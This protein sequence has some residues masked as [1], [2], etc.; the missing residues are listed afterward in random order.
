[1][2]NNL[3]Y[4][5]DKKTPLFL[6]SPH[7][8]ES[9]NWFVCALREDCGCLDIFDK[10]DYIQ[11][12]VEFYQKSDYFELFLIGLTLEA[13]KI[14]WIDNTEEAFQKIGSLIHKM[15]EHDE[16]YESFALTNNK[17][18]F[19]ILHTHGDATTF[20][21]GKETYI[22]YQLGTDNIEKFMHR[23][24]E[25]IRKFANFCKPFPWSIVGVDNERY[26]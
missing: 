21:C 25:C 3:F 16:Y 8:V 22:K 1:M 23:Y 13:I 9:K 26:Y 5:Q 4:V 17:C 18:D 14:L 10:K 15:H 6:P 20:I 2:C 7:I 24:Y 12:T 11:K 19:L